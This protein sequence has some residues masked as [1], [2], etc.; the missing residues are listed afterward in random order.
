MKDPYK[1]RGREAHAGRSARVGTA[2]DTEIDAVYLCPGNREYT[3][4]QYYKRFGNSK[5]QRGPGVKT[6]FERKT[7]CGKILEIDDRG[8]AFCPICSKIFNSGPAQDNDDLVKD[9]KAVEAG[10][11]LKRRLPRRWAAA[12][13]TASAA[14]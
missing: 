11:P 8:F 12:G 3:A 5:L 9:L 1:A 6:S 2:W 4:L 7:H 14:H 10:P 13:R